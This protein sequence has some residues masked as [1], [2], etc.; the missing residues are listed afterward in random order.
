[1]EKRATLL[2]FATDG[3]SAFKVIWKKFDDH[4]LTVSLPVP[5]LQKERAMSARLATLGKVPV[6]EQAPP[7]IHRS[8]G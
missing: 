5:V 7:T 3:S 8:C 6:L 4:F 1:L 2:L